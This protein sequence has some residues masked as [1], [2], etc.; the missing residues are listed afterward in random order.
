VQAVG[1]AMAAGDRPSAPLAVDIAI[2]G[3]QVCSG[4]AAI[5]HDV[6]AL[7]RAVQ[8]EEVEYEVTL[9]GDGAETEVFFSDLSHEY[10]S[11]NADYT[12]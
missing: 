4:G 1:A 3:I 12:T 10:V 7:E 2:E 9:P 11:I 5:P 6:Q 8:R